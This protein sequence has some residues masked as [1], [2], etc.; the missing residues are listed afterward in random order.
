MWGMEG[1]GGVK[2]QKVLPGLYQQSWSLSMACA[3]V[4]VFSLAL[5]DSSFFKVCFQ[6]LPVGLLGEASAGKRDRKTFM[7]YWYK[8]WQYGSLRSTCADQGR[9]NSVRVR[10]GERKRK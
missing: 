10:E 3:N 7:K 4:K 2:G 9:E 8:V 5:V 1:G 6:V